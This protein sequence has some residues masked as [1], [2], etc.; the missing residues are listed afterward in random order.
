MPIPKPTSGE[1]QQEYISRCISEIS[2]EYEQE[3][4][5]AI[6]YSTWERESM[7]EEVTE[8][9]QQGGV[10]SG[11]FSKFEYSPKPKEKL[12][13]FMGRCMG[14]AQVRER[15]QDRVG[16]AAFCY[17]EYRNN[18]IMSIAKSWK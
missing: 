4:G 8:E 15:K 1:K 11:S 3:Q 9:Q 17:S 13:D 10:V 5:L 12:S 18:Y 6:C 16:R 2:G 7:S 14:D